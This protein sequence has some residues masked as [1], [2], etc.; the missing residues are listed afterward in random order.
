MLKN[1]IR[2]KYILFYKLQVL[3]NS[4]FVPADFLAYV[5]KAELQKKLLKCR[6]IAKEFKY[7]D[8]AYCN[9]ES[10]DI[11]NAICDGD[12]NR[13]AKPRNKGDKTF[14]TSRNTFGGSVSGSSDR[15]S[16]YLM[17]QEVKLSVKCFIITI[18]CFEIIH[19]VW[20]FLN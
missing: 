16:F 4:N 10:M 20:L 14:G 19:F 1:C 3:S 12:E 13:Y 9:G 15:N 17:K 7:I 5:Q 18:S 8:D 6:E 2:V 11:L